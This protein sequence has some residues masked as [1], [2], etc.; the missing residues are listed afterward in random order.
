MDGLMMLSQMGDPKAAETLNAFAK[1]VTKSP[2]KK[3]AKQADRVLLISEARNVLQGNIEKAPALIASMTKMLAA[4]PDDIQT[5][6]LA[7][8][9][10]GAFEHVKGGETLSKKPML[11]SVLSLQKAAMN[12][13]RN[14]RRVLKGSFADSTFQA[15]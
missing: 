5:A 3:L 14:S 1:I 12:R 8:Q 11:P 13:Y 10:A 7:M 6:Q 9:L 15:M 4:D 2:F